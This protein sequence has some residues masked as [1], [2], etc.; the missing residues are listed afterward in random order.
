MSCVFLCF[1]FSGFVVISRVKT[2]WRWVSA[3]LVFCIA[4]AV[5]YLLLFRAL[6]LFFFLN[7]SFW[8]LHI[9]LAGLPGIRLS[10]GEGRGKWKSCEFWVC[11]Q[12]L[13]SCAG[14]FVLS[15]KQCSFMCKASQI[16]ES[17]ALRNLL[18]HRLR[19]LLLLCVKFVGYH[20]ICLSPWLS[21][22]VVA[23]MWCEGWLLLY[24]VPVWC[25]C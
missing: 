16:F 19:R 1:H 23:W 22:H 20:G 10:T 6:L 8:V 7:S 5:L 13:R 11:W 3:E 4:S 15:S 21:I 25:R 18:L 2:R 12:C 17:T 14:V 24:F 9:S